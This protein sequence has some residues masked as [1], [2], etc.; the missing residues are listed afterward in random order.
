[1]I[2]QDMD[3]GDVRVTNYGRAKIGKFK[4]MP[5]FLILKRCNSLLEF[6]EIPYWISAGTA[7]GLYRDGDFIPHDTDIDVEVLGKDIK[8]YDKLIDAFK[9]EGFRLFRKMICLNNNKCMQLAF[10]NETWE[11]IY[12]IYI[13]Y[14]EGGDNYINHNEFGVLKIP[15]RMVDT[16]EIIGDYIF[17]SDIEEYLKFRYGKDWR[18]P[19]TSKGDWEKEMGEALK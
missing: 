17:P 8:S 15:K 14:D 11:V 4:D 2:I 5:G 18:T 10:Y 13:Y 3:F 1:M 19:K 9:E 6:L 16:K 12:D 7:L